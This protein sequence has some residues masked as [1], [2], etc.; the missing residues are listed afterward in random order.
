MKLET[1]KRIEQAADESGFDG[2]VARGDYSGRGMYGSTTAA[3]TGSQQAI[4][5]AIAVAAYHLGQE[6]PDD[7]EDF[8][9][10]VGRLRWDSMG[11]DAIAY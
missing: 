11:R 2:V 4:V 8:L 7:A 3:V 5:A 1:A 6:G 10:D 9:E